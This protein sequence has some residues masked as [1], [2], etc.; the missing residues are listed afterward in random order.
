M[1]AERL[2]L[3]YLKKNKDKRH[4]MCNG[5]RTGFMG[6]PDFKFYKYQT[7]ANN[8]SSLKKRG[9]IKEVNGVWLI[10][11]KGEDFLQKK[12]RSILKKFTTNKTKTDPKDLLLFYD[13]PQGRTTLRNWLRRELISFHFEMIQRS[14]WVGPSPLP[15]EFLVYIGSLGLTKNIKT[16]KLKKGYIAKN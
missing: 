3:E 14:V 5:V 7:M 10:T 4:V 13:I 2:I 11:Y 15:R 9:F 1:S 16:F 12:E 8:L 6:L